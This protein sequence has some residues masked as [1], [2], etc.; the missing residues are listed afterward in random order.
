MTCPGSTHAQN[1]VLVKDDT[2]GATAVQAFIAALPDWKRD[3]ATEFD[4]I[5]NPRCPD[6]RHAVKWHQ[7][8]YGVE[9]EGWF[10]SFSAFS[11]R[12]K[13][14]FISESYL[15]PEPPS[16]TAPDRQAIDLEETDTLNEEQLTSWVRQ[17]ATDPGMGW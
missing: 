9:D 8:F 12:V 15:D 17:A 2:D 13:L 16:V 4:E 10:A 1:T 11:K 7:P 6:V 14:S 5:V 3:V